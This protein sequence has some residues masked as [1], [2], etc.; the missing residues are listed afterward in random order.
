MARDSRNVRRKRR[1]RRNLS[2]ARRQ[3]STLTQ[4]YFKTF[5]TLLAVLAQAG[6][7]VTV[8][9]GTATQVLDNLRTLGWNTVAGA[10]SDE[11]IVR[12]VEGVG[13]DTPAEPVEPTVVPLDTPVPESLVPVEQVTGD[14]PV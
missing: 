10:T 2:L 9:K 7:E 4:D 1:T 11:F 14:Q 8:T 6:G 12:L 5:S 3:V 13:P